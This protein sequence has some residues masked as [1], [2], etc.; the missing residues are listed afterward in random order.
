VTDGGYSGGGLDW[1]T[2]FSLFT[3][4]GL[5]VAY[6]LLG[7]TWL[8]MK[9]EG[10]LQHRMKDLARP[11]TMIVLATIAIV[12]FWTPLSHPAVAVR[13]LSLPNV[14]LFAPVP[15]LVLLATWAILRTLR[16]DSHAAPFLFAQLLL[17]LGYSGL[18]ISLWPTS[19]HPRF[20]SGTRPRL[21]KVWVSH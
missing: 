16:R 5:V 17:F 10:A 1:L 9:T 18:A 20:P 14:L 3:G 13:W 15:I 7:S 21:P 4:F 2:P 12:S 8:V 19:S 6:A 11:V